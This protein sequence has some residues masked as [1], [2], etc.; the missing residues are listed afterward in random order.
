MRAAILGFVAGAALLQRQAE[1][2]TVPFLIFTLCLALLVLAASTWLH[3]AWLRLALLAAA[4]TVAGLA[5]A[6]LVAQT[7]LANELPRALEGQDLT[8]VGVIDSLPLRFEQG[9]R[10]HFK[11]EQVDGAARPARFPERIALSWYAGGRDQDLSSVPDVRAGERWTLTVRLRRP[12]GNANPYG[13]DYEVWLLEQKLRATGHVRGDAGSGSANRRLD[14]FVPGF[15][16]AVERLRA[17]L[18]EKI[19]RALPDHRYA[20]VIVALVIG[21]QRAIEQA[22]WDVF[23]R[24]GV[25]HLIS[26]SG[27]HI[28]MIASLCAALVLALWR[29]S[30]FTGLQLPLRLP[31][32]KAAALAGALSAWTYV[33]LAGS[34]VPAQRTLV[35]LVV[36]A[37]A[38]WVGRA[39]RVSHVLCTALGMVVLLDPWAVLAPGFWLSFS[40]VALILYTTTGRGIALAELPRR[41]RWMAQL[42]AAAHM[43]YAITVGLVPLT[44][45]LFAQV[46][47][48]SPIANAVAIPVIS[49]F[50]TPAA[51]VGSMLPSPLADWVLR[52]GH[53]LVEWLAHM[54]GWL[55]ALPAATWSAPVP[56]W[57]ALIAALVGVAWLLAPRGWPLRALGLVLLLPLLLTGVA[58]PA[59]GQLWVTAFDVGQGSAVLLETAG[60]RL[61]YDTGPAYSPQS[62][63]GS[64]V[65]LPYLKGRGIDMLDTLVISHGDTDHVGGARSLMDGVRVERVSSSL[66]STHPVVLRAREHR[67]C[68]AG[69]SWEWDGVRF[70]MLYPAPAVYESEKWKANARSCTLKVSTKKHAV[71][72]PGD[73]EAIQEGHLL[74]AGAEQLR[75]DVLLAPH[76]GSGTSSTRP[77]L[78]AVAPRLA[79]F[80][81]GHANRYRHP[82]EEVY[83]RYGEL[84]IE[85]L[86]TDVAGAVSLRFADEL[87]FVGY[88]AEQPRYWHGR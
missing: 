66:A 57:W 4:G 71:L 61:L 8:V 10:F 6:G 27:L 45:L 33:L 14:N 13:F 3:K 1:L 31:A 46:S 83:Q 51:L 64:R 76:H 54:L 50:V 21:D 30:F 38:M 2:P 40:A 41:Q 28:T 86:R 79:I 19:Q 81:V 58:A 17:G 49:F 65:I 52:A 63:G 55:S 68:E 74:A 25:G 87:A 47:L 9:T 42:H 32:Q 62:D 60:H 75:S 44:L 39:T 56:P 12:H 77:F 85:R 22:D 73:I 53:A 26:I 36:V 23:N 34:G 37:L 84:G 48:V 18:R 82:K 59:P 35:M 80:Q 24:T 69:Q 16:H 78:Q 7:Y 70:E 67:R 72:L 15:S 88:R 5:W 20:G 29:R 43:Q 11:V